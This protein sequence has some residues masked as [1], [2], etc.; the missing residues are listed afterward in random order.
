MVTVRWAVLHWQFPDTRSHI[1]TT[2]MYMLT[3]AYT[4]IYTQHT[5]WH[6]SIPKGRAPSTGHLAVEWQVAVMV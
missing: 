5:R 1:H 2:C 6:S 3:H 4:L